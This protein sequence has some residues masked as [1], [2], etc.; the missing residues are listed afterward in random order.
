MRTLSEKVGYFF[1][2]IFR[3]TTRELFSSFGFLIKASAFTAGTVAGDAGTL[4]SNEYETVLAL[5]SVG[6]LA[7]KKHNTPKLSV[8]SREYKNCFFMTYTAESRGNQKVRSLP[9]TG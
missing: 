8:K 7:T 3:L 5:P 2:A 1:L 9:A 4:G 6:E